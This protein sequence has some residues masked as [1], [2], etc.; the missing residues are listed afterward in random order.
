MSYIDIAIIVV[1]ALG[2]LIGL[3]KGFFKTLISFFGWFVSFLVA[4][5]ITKPIVGALLDV[6][7]IKNFVVGNG[8][9][10]S[11][12]TWIYAKLP[13]LNGSGVLA[14]LLRPL[15]K[16]VEEVGGTD[17]STGVALLIANGIFSVAVC[18][19]LFIIIRI[20]LLL[21]TMFANAMTQNKLV[22]ALN[23]LLGLVLG[24]VKGAWFVGMAMIVLTFL[25][26]MSFMAPVRA[27]MDKSVL[28]E[29]IYNQVVKLTD[30]FITGGKDTLIKLLD[31]Y[32]RNG[33]H[34]GDDGEEQE[35]AAEL[36]MYTSYNASD[37][38][39]EDFKIELKEDNKF[40]QYSGLSQL[41]GTY[42]IDGDTITLT[43]DNGTVSQCEYGADGWFKL[44]EIYMCKNGVTPP[45]PNPDPDPNP[46]PAFAL[47]FA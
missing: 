26:G 13:D 40:T 8:E 3:W 10:W 37:F 25:M 43:F 18:I 23:R 34:G 33:S 2:A 46:A 39:T 19:C 14:T 24:A 6:K 45:A 12:F 4:F 7:G 29:P 22:G 41:N 44:G 42:A 31:I 21:F 15:T 17:L 16:I 20:L 28:A 9:S 11:L 47:A 35:P 5:F 38:D 36:G 27:Q 32:E 1:V 30:K